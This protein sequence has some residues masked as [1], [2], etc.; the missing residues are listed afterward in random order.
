MEYVSGPAVF[1]RFLQCRLDGSRVN[2]DPRIPK[3]P[4]VKIKNKEFAYFQEV[5]CSLLKTFSEL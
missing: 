3:L 2:L 4:S 5:K 1:F